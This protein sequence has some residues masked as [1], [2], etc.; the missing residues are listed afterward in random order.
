PLDQVLAE[1]RRLHAEAD[2][3]GLSPTEP[4]NDVLA[5]VA[6][7]PPAG[8]PD[9]AR[10]ARS[11]G[12]GMFPP[13]H[14]LAGVAARSAHTTASRATGLSRPLYGPQCPFTKRVAHI[15]AQAAEAL[16]YAASQ[17]VLHRDVKPSNLLLDVWGTVWLTDF[18]LAKA[19]GTPDLTR[20]GD[21]VGTLRY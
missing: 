16:E 7:A 8:C 20:T 11:L 2:R 21:L 4:G 10:V 17:G 19:T 5:G 9:S 13:G 3:R 18:G 15:G 6:T 14:Q 12:E 1:L